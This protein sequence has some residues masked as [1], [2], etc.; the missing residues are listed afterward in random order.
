MLVTCPLGKGSP[1]EVRPMSGLST[2]SVMAIAKDTDMAANAAPPYRRR[3]THASTT[4]AVIVATGTGAPGQTRTASSRGCPLRLAFTLASI[5]VSTHPVSIPCCSH[6]PCT[7]TTSAQTT[8]IVTAK[9]LAVSGSNGLATGWPGP[10]PACRNAL[11]PINGQA[12]SIRPDRTRRPARDFLERASRSTRRPRPGPRCSSAWRPA[13]RQCRP[14]RPRGHRQPSRC[15]NAP[16]Q[17]RRGPN[18]VRRSPFGSL[19]G[20]PVTS[21]VNSAQAHRAGYG[22][23]VVNTTSTQ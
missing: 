8:T 2:S 13:C 5:A 19:V 17:T 3:R 14:A 9:G 21:R 22:D 4:A 20:V 16:S 6:T 23:V 18:A 11:P 15:R 7:A 1:Q 10:F 12:S